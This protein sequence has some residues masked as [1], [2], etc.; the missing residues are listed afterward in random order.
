MFI[1]TAVCL[2]S[3]NCKQFALVHVMQATGLLMGL[4]MGAGGKSNDVGCQ[5]STW[6]A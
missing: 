1:C 4:L 5:P 3:Q 2:T 6:D